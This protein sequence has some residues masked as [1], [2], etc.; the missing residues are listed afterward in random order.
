MLG[1]VEGSCGVVFS[2]CWKMF[3][4]YI[5]CKYNYY[6]NGVFFFKLACYLIATPCM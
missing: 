6:I 2:F 3:L 5:T 1:V 4:K